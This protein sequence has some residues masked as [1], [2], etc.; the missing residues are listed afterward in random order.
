MEI[1]IVAPLLYG[2]VMTGAV[3]WDRAPIGVGVHRQHMDALRRAA[4][5]GAG[6]RMRR[7]R[8]A[9]CSTICR[10]VGSHARMRTRLRRGG[11]RMCAG[12]LGIC[13]E[14][15]GGSDGFFL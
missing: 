15:M 3:T 2:G 5:A 10:R 13:I 12:D 11:I 6:G 9:R 1:D 7:W 4:D 8:G 14:G